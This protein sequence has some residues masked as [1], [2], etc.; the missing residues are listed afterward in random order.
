MIIIMIIINIYR[1]DTDVVLKLGVNNICGYFQ[2]FTFDSVLE[3]LLKV[4][5]SSIY[6]DLDDDNHDDD[7]DNQNHTPTAS[8]HIDA[9]LWNVKSKI[10]IDNSII[11][12]LLLLFAW[13]LSNVE[14]DTFIDSPVNGN[15]R[16]SLITWRQFDHPHVAC[17]NIEG[18]YQMSS[19]SKWIESNLMT[20]EWPGGHQCNQ[21]SSNRI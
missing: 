9:K 13:K 16:Q 1:D 5:Q 15:F 14:L 11:S 21:K 12:D 18:S 10:S 6:D 7:N 20:R 17:C 19:Q 2:K 4:K 3:N 8:Y